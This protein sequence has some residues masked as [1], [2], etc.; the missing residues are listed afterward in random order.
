MTRGLAKMEAPIGTLIAFS[1]QAGQQA[2]DG[3]GHN[4]PYTTAFLKHIDE[5]SEIGDI[6]RD[7][8]ADV[9]RAT[10][11][12]Q[13]P[14]LSLSIIGKFYLQGTV[15]VTVP[16]A[17]T[18][19]KPDPCAAAE[20]HW[21]A[22]DLLGTID[23]YEDHI[24][25]FPSCAFAGLAQRRIDKLKASQAK[26]MPAITPAELPTR[27]P[28][29]SEWLTPTE[30]QKLFDAKVRERQYP[31]I[32]EATVYGDGILLHAMFVP[33]P[34]GRF[35]FYSYT[36]MSRDV[37]NQRNQLFQRDGYTLAHQQS[38]VL[39]GSELVQATWTR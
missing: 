26:A 29:Y 5:P 28:G 30:Y 15:Q 13:L 25:R 1:T 38:V 21:K 20:T 31:Q 2:E 39:S 9:Y 3:H 10:D 32:V 19:P 14:E 18:A 37:F 12:R 24:A 7:I 6:F 23:A 4:S 33:C 35:F 36:G 16:Q 22:A 11:N 34:T 27:T 8:S 17:A